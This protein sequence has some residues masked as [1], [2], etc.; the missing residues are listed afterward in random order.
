MFLI[1]SSVFDVFSTFLSFCFSPK[2]FALKHFFLYFPPCVL[3]ARTAGTS[4]AAHAYVGE[5]SALGNGGGCR[6]F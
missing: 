3:S 5:S 2:V 1:F 4:L 6:C